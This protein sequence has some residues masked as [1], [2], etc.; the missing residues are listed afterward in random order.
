MISASREVVPPCEKDGLVAEDVVHHSAEEGHIRLDSA[1]VKKSMQANILA[2]FSHVIG[3]G[4]PNVPVWMSLSALHAPL[5]LSQT[6]QLPL[7][8]LSGRVAR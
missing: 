4:P 1:D 8:D 2:Y 6:T 3:C 5:A 7:Q